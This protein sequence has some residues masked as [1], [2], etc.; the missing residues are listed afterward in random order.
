MRS[1][2]ARSDGLPE[3]GGTCTTCSPLRPHSPLLSVSPFSLPAFN[4]AAFIRVSIPRLI[5]I[6]SS[7]LF[8]YLTQFALEAKP[9]C[10]SAEV[11]SGTLKC[12]WRRGT[13]WHRLAPILTAD[14][15]VAPRSLATEE[16]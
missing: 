3:H 7:G 16:H 13:S 5:R 6:P 2:K 1:A 4:L 12:H 9:G 8:L 11:E 15:G 14:S 10:R